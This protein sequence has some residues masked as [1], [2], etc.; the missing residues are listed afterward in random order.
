[1]YLALTYDHRLLDGREAV[2]FLVKVCFP[3]QRAYQQELALHALQ[4]L[5][6]LF[7]LRSS[8]TSRILGACYWGDDPLFDLL[9]VYLLSFSVRL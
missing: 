3:G 7:L 1:M 4:Q 5:I 6:I 9:V 8:N 2:T